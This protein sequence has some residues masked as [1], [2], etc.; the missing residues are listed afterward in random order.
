MGARNWRG[1]QRRCNGSWPNPLPMDNI[2][3]SDGSAQITLIIPS[4]WTTWMVK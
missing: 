1:V 4:K 3:T 2:T